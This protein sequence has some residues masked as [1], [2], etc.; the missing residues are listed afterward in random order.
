MNQDNGK[1]TRE[2]RSV[3]HG[4]SNIWI[5]KGVALCNLERYEETL[6]AYDIALE[7]YP[8]YVGAWIFKL[9]VLCKLGRDEEAESLEKEVY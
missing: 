4:D 2:N 8:D 3:E 5:G 6:Q 7:L 9:D 1:F